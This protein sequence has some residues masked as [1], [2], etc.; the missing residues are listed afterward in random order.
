[1]GW[2]PLWDGIILSLV[3]LH[4]DLTLPFGVWLGRWGGVT[5]LGFGWGVGRHDLTQPCS[6]WLGGWGGVQL[7]HHDCHSRFGWGVGRVTL[8]YHDLTLPF[9]VGGRPKRCIR[10]GPKRCTRG[11]PKRHPCHQSRSQQEAGNNDGTGSFFEQRKKRQEGKQEARQAAE[12]EPEPARS[13]K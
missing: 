12:P 9:K 4:H 11:G 1:M 13:R 8:L 10:G 7:L 6:V 3:L 2:L 5:H